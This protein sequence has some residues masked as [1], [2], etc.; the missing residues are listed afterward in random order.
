MPDRRHARILAMQS[1]CQLDVLADDFLP[2]LDRFLAEETPDRAVRDYARRLVHESWQRRDELD[3]AIQA[4]A[5][6]WDVRRMTTVDRNVL[7]VAVCE[8]LHRPE[9]PPPVAIDEAVEIG[10]TFSTADSAA[11][12]NGVLDAV[13]QRRTAEKEASRGGAENAEAEEGSRGGAENA[14]QP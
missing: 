13:L 9:I 4:V 3:A 2:Q 10:K 12:I 1:L 11:F 6:H 5:E 7:R 8:L 14:E